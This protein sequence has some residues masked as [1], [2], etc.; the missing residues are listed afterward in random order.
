MEFETRNKTLTNADAKDFCSWQ[1]KFFFG[2]LFVFL[3]AMD[4]LTFFPTRRTNV[5]VA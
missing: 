2:S 4:H 1:N 3:N 5:L